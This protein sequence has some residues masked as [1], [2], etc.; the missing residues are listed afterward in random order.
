MVNIYEIFSDQYT[1]YIISAATSLAVLYNV[2]ILEVDI[3][4]DILK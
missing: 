1:I 3:K 2:H 4:S